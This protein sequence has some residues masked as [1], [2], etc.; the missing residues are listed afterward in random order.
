MQFQ[1]FSHPFRSRRKFAD[2]WKL[3]KSNAAVSQLVK[4]IHE[5]GYRCRPDQ[6]MTKKRAN[7]LHSRAERG[8][9]SY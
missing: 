5:R 2:Y 7:Y 3:R 1:P 4:E 8:L 9:L 6:T